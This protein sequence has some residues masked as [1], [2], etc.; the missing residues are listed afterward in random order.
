MNH[1]LLTLNGVVAAGCVRT[2]YLVRVESS[3]IDKTWNGFNVFVAGIAE[4]NLGIM[5]ACAPSVH[6]FFKD[7]FRNLTK[8][9]GYGSSQGGNSSSQSGAK[10]EVNGR[11]QRSEVSRI[12]ADNDVERST[13]HSKKYRSSPIRHTAHPGA[14]VYDDESGLEEDWTNSSKL[15][16]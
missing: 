3:D 6:H 2:Y 9:T 5:C 14:I 8:V 12:E 11:S 16:V 10:S 15:V 1:N 13:A 7:F 4:L